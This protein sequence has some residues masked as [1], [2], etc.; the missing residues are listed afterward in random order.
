[1][2]EEHKIR[3]SGLGRPLGLFR[4]RQTFVADSLIIV[5][6]HLAEEKSVNFLTSIET[7]R[8]PVDA[9][10]HIISCYFTHQKLLRLLGRFYI[11]S[12]IHACDVGI[13]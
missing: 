1:M 2:R 13:H 8:F 10:R 9:V 6:Q 12:R 3:I 5:M 7:I 11:W 4:S